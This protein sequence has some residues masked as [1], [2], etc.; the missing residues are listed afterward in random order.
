M[1]LDKD[2][3][4]FEKWIGVPHSTVEG[5][6]EGTY[7]SDNVM[8]G[9]PLGLQPTLKDIFTVIEQD[10][11]S[12]LRVS[13]EIYAGLTTLDEYEN[14]HLSADFKWGDKKWEPRLDLKR[15]SGILYHCY[16]PHGRFWEVWKTS[17]EYQVQETDLGDFISIGGNTAKPPVGGPSANIRG[18]KNAE[19]L[20]FDPE[21]DDYFTGR[22]YIHAA[23]E[24]DKPHGQW[25]RLELYV[26][27]G[28][29]VHVVNGEV[30]MVVEDAKKPDGTPLAKGQIQIQ[31]E[32]A[33][34]YYKN[35]VLTPIDDFPNAIKAKVRF[36]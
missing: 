28:T 15:D 31:S 7:Q 18:D 26:I 24:P 33:E 13:G 5:L 9:E 29:G 3:S 32:A 35:I 25:N 1:A 34:C 6:P 20:R 19:P 23:S 27:G 22:G 36:K 17:L 2:L 8:K 4:K 16:G 10:G 21:S 11:E 30:V 14:Y 12:V